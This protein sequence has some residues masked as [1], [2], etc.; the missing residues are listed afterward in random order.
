MLTQ[1]ATS[2]TV[3]AGVK[4]SGKP[5]RKRVKTTGVTVVVP[6]S[7]ERGADIDISMLPP[8]AE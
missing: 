5:G 6:E 3:D 7:A 4:G 8:S 2:S 1:K